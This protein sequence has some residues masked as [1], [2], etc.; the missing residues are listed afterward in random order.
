MTISW[1]GSLYTD[2]NLNGNYQERWI[3]APSQGYAKK[4]RQTFNYALLVKSQQSPYKA[5]NMIVGTVAQKMTLL[6][7]ASQ[8]NKENVNLIRQVGGV[9]LYCG[10]IMDDTYTPALSTIASKQAQLTERTLKKVM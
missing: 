1:T 2:T 7:E 5:P 3:E 4:L 9:C 8:L 10:R 6:H